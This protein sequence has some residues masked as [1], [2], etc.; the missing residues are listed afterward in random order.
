[1]SENLELVRSIF[2]A[3]ERGEYFANAEWAHAEIEYVIVDGPSPGSW[4]G[5]AAMAGAGRDVLNATEDGRTEAEEYRQP[6]GER[7]VPRAHPLRRAGRGTARRSREPWAGRTPTRL[8]PRQ[9]RG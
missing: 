8:Q 2:A 7:G 4:T 5:L 1:M 3:W 9:R 6:D